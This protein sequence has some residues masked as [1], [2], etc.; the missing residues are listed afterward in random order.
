VKPTEKFP[1]KMRK[2]P[3]SQGISPAGSLPPREKGNDAAPLGRAIL[4]GDAPM[5]EPAAEHAARLVSPRHS[6]ASRSGEPGTYIP[7]ARVHGFRASL[8]ARSR[9]DILVQICRPSA[10]DF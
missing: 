8:C 4:A 2:I 1:D 9:D 7:G 6:G 10:A 3:C 5:I